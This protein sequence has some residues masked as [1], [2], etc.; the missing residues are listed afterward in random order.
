MQRVVSPSEHI[1][2]HEKYDES[3]ESL[4]SIGPHQGTHMDGINLSV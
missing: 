1:A 2:S 3:H 4:Q